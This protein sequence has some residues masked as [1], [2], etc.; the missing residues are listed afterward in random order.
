MFARRA[1]SEAQKLV[2]QANNEAQAWRN[3]RKNHLSRQASLKQAISPNKAS[4]STKQDKLETF[5]NLKFPFFPGE[6]LAKKLAR[7]IFFFQTSLFLSRRDKEV[8]DSKLEDT[9]EWIKVARQLI[10]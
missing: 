4:V 6:A 2:Q 8:W 10:K 3:I 1:S 5:P 7:W 9:S